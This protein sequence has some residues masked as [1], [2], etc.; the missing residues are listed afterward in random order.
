MKKRKYE[1]PVA[2]DLSGATVQGQNTPPPG[3]CTTGQAPSQT[4][5]FCI[6]GSAP[7]AGNCHVGFAPSVGRCSTGGLP[8]SVC[9]TGSAPN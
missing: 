6:S 8:A 9:L 4:E 7:S 3:S 2:M 5:G 1:R